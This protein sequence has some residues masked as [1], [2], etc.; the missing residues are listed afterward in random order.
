MLYHVPLNHTLEL[1]QIIVHKLKTCDG[2]SEL[3]TQSTFPRFFI[4]GELAF[5]VTMG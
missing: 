3:I 2:N 1:Q 4:F 5:P